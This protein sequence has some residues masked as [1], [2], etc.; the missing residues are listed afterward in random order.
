MLRLKKPGGEE[1]S[2]RNILKFYEFE[3]PIDGFN[4]RLEYKD[5]YDAMDENKKPDTIAYFKQWKR[6]YRWP[7]STPVE[8]KE[9]ITGLNK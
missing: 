9:D 2:V 4:D 6:T 7:D 3:K 8:P 5:I 1:E